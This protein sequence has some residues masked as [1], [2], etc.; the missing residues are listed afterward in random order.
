MLSRVVGRGAAGTV[1]EAEH[2]LLTSK[3]ALKFLDTAALL[4]PTSAE[5]L[6]QRFRFEAQIS[7]RLAPLT[8]HLV[9]S[10]DAGMFRG[11]PYLVMELVDGET[12]DQRLSRGRMDPAAVA[13][14][15]DQL[16]EPI[17]AAHTTGIA[18]RD[19]KPGNIMILSNRE[20]PFYKIGDFGTAKSFGDVLVGLTPPKQTSE[21]TLVG[22]PAYMSPEYI[23]G[24]PLANGAIDV[25]ALA[26][27][28]YEALTG[29][30]PFDGEVW[31]Q[32]AVAIVAGEFTPPSQAAED[33]PTSLD[34]VF[35]RAF[36]QEV[37]E[38]FTNAR[39]FARVVRQALEAPPRSQTMVAVE[40]PIEVPKTNHGRTLAIGA[41]VLLTLGVVF[42]GAKLLGGGNVEAASS[43]N[44][45][46]APSPVVSASA[47]AVATS[48]SAATVPTATAEQTASALSAASDPAVA[49]SAPEDPRRPVATGQKK[50]RPVNKSE[51]Q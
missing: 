29:R 43:T 49:S 37:S 12:L 3:V 8:K 41:G 27:T 34:E 7:A 40:T 6:A 10:H 24:L 14:M 23:S 42:I 28:A 51:V 44:A 48:P 22:S 21:N 17:D 20:K 38:R 18:H 9:S 5:I 50:R 2:R 35:A 4:D 19:I 39:H 32:V 16:A 30:L 1:W 15:L 45:T 31:T 11:I 25:W 13:D 46:A 47:T 36:S 26:V 33:I